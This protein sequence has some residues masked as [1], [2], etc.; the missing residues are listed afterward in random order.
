MSNYLSRLV[1]RHVD[2]S[3]PMLHPRIPSRFEDVSRSSLDT[4][5]DEQVNAGLAT[6]PSGF[7]RNKENNVQV[8]SSSYESRDS[9]DQQP[10]QSLLLQPSDLDSDLALQHRLSAAEHALKSLSGNDAANSVA[11]HAVNSF[12]PTVAIPS[13]ARSIPSIETIQAHHYHNELHTEV[14]QVEYVPN[15]DSQ[16]LQPEAA[17]ETALTQHPAS[18]NPAP[19]IATE[20]RRSE[21]RV[22]APPTIVAESLPRDAS[23]NNT[24]HVSIGRIEIRSPAPKPE[25]KKTAQP[26]TQARIMTLDEYVRQRTGGLR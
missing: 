7:E 17:Q 21:P 9:R 6:Y 11:P 15:Q 1:Q 26:S 16:I 20:H 18:K 24:V 3:L 22:Q 14:V 2:S 19:Q 5:S 13:A 4:A 8:T 23:E 10:T 12:Q 25:P